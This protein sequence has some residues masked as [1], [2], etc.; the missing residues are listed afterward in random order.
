MPV[1]DDL[2]EQAVHLARRERRKPKQISLRRS[3]RG[4]LRFVPSVHHGDGAQLEDSVST[5]GGFAIDGAW[6]NEARIRE[7]R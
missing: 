1:A 4:I 7:D 2:L 3:L 5:A 6:A